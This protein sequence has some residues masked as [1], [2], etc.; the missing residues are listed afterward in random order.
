MNQGR[1]PFFFKNNGKGK[2]ANSGFRKI[3]ATAKRQKT[4]QNGKLKK[5]FMLQNLL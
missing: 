5:I 3:T 4:R 1:R 2:T